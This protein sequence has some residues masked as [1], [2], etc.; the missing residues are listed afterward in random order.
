MADNLRALAVLVVLF[1]PFLLF[2]LALWLGYQG[3]ER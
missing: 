2:A 1:A 3:M